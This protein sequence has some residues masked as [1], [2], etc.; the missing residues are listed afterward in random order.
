MSSRIGD[1]SIVRRIAVG[2]MAEVYLA[3]HD[4]I[5]GVARYVVVKRTLESLIDDEDLTGMLL[6]EARLLAALSHPN[7]AQ[8]FDCG[9]EEGAHYLVMEY[10]RGPTLRKLLSANVAKTG[11]G[12]A[13]RDALAIAVGVCEALAYVHDRRDESGRPLRIVHRDLNP[14]NIIVSWDGA[15]KLIDFG[16]AKGALRRNETRVGVVKGTYGYMAPEQLTGDSPIDHRADVFALGVVLY[17]MC[18][19]KHPFEDT[20]LVGLLTRIVTSNYVKPRRLVPEIKPDLEKLIIRCLAPSPAGRPDDVATVLI[21]V[22]KVLRELD[23]LPSMRD[24]ASLAKRLVPDEE[25]PI[26]LKP[27]SAVDALPRMNIALPVDATSERPPPSAVQLTNEDMDLTGAVRIVQ[28]SRRRKQI[29]GAVVL[30]AIF[31]G[32]PGYV[33]FVATAKRTATTAA[34]LRPPPLD[35][36]ASAV[37]EMCGAVPR[38]PNTLCVLSEPSGATVLIDGNLSQVRT[39]AAVPIGSAPLLRIGVRLEGYRAQERSLI[40]QPGE[41]RF[42]LERAE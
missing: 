41:A 16:I 35:D 30:A 17:E 28:A 21:E 15:V 40:A 31:I 7:I 10:V 13:V 39:P 23:D 4:G 22:Q 9:I 1:Y 12:F 26:P 6:D 42:E 14:A 25:G 29:L 36:G 5:E 37:D 19:G 33:L 18:T 38:P 3:R 20:N 8:V 2:G 24:L 32:V 27:L 34:P 11:K